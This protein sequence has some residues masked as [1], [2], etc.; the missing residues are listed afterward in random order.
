[1]NLPKSLRAAGIAVAAIVLALCSCSDDG[2]DGP[3]PDPDCIGPSG[4]QA[5][6][7]D[8]N[9]AFDGVALTVDPG[10]WDQC[11]T[12]VFQPYSPFATPDFP[13]GLTGY[14]N[15]L[16]GSVRLS[17]GRQVTWEQWEEAPS[18]LPM[19]LTFPVG[20]LTVEPGEKLV[21]FRYDE[22]AG[23]YRL[24]FPDRV[25]DGQLTVSTGDHASLWTWGKVD[26]GEVDFDAYLAPA[27]EELHGAGVWSAVEAKLD[28]LR[29][30]TSGGAITANC[31]TLDAVRSALV[32]AHAG[33]GATLRAIQNSLSGDCGLCDATS[34]AFSAELAAYFRLKVAEILTD[35]FTSGSR[36]PYVR[37]YGCIMTGY[38]QHGIAEL[39]CDFPC[40]S[41]SVGADYYYNL[42]IYHVAAAMVELIDWA[43]AGGFINCG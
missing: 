43:M 5:A 38:Q 34:P 39:D 17:I 26:L 32:I 29:Q 24:V 28:S 22:A 20:A 42:A 37:L 6:V 14:A 15:F 10:A 9:S 8:T 25:D 19:H 12:V 41:D 27:M 7:T 30:A 3:P 33:A 4:G 2:P 31:T 21:A 1:M 11:W 23:K 18:P 13:D 35:L 40:L 16:T 36:N